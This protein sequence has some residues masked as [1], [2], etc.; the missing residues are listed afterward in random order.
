MPPRLAILV[1]PDAILFDAT[2]PAEVFGRAADPEGRPL[3]DVQVCGP[4]KR[5]RAGPFALTIAA[6]LE[7][8]DAADTI[9]VAGRTRLDRPS[10]DVI[11]ALRHAADRG[12]R[13]A[14]ICTGAFV[15]AATG[16]L[17]GARAT[18]HWAAADALAR[19]HPEIEVD[20]SVLYVDNGRTLTSAGAAA[21]MDLCLHMV[22]T[23]H[24]A[25][26]AAGVARL[27]VVPLERDG[28]QAQFV[29]PESPPPDESDSLASLLGWIEANV[30]RPLGLDDLAVEAAMSKRT[31]SRRFREQ[32]GTSPAQWVARARVRRAQQLLETTDHSVERIA[33]LAGF[34]NESTLRQRFR[35][36][37][38]NAPRAYRGLFRSGADG[39]APR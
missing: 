18:T 11:D 22:R 34:A 3:Y 27:S 24:G 12:A 30:H 13:L 28:G 31:L 8:L 33:S 16:V 20:P 25:A 9:V 19:R 7:T 15:L 37:V 6:G 1:L 39:A 26:V 14:S 29:S 21:G 32:T 2:V 36:I 23:D 10:T 17:D 38:G 4:S 5:T 35:R